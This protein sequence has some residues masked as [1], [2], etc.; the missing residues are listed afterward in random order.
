MP[1]GGTGK[2]KYSTIHL[3]LT[4]RPDRAHARTHGTTRKDFW[5]GLP[6]PI[7]NTV[8]NSI[9]ACIHIYIYIYI[10]EHESKESEMYIYIYIYTERDRE[11][12]MGAGQE[13]SR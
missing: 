6:P 7:S 1:A 5:V 3:I 8:S 12:Y 10:Y 4:K 2:D 13:R 11:R 9:T